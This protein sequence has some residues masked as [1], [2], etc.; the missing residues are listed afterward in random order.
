MTHPP[1]PGSW[2]APTP[3]VAAVPTPPPSAFPL[4]PTDHVRFLRTPRHR[5]W[6]SL[7]LLV[8]ATTGFLAVTTVAVL[9][10]YAIDLATGR[11][12]MAELEDQFR[13]GDLTLTPATFLANNVG[14]ALLIPLSGLLVWA[15][16]GQRPRWL[17]SVVGGIRWR[18][19][20]IV[21]AALTPIW[22]VAT[23]LGLVGSWRE[24]RVGPDTALLVVGILLT[25]PFQA[26][27]EE[28]LFRGLG[29]RAVG[30]FFAREKLALAAG[31]VLPSL[32]FMLAHGA[33]DPWLNLFYLVFGLSASWMT[34]RTG[35]LEAAI[36]LH[37]VNNLASAV[38]LPFT[39]ISNVMD[40]QAGVVQAVDIVPTLV[41]LVLGVVVVEVLTRRLRPARLGPP[42]G[43][44]AVTGSPYTQA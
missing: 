42:S 5:W 38:S 44:R 4:Q 18:W 21:A 19:L 29:A 24:F 16:T 15:F 20:L 17:S 25:Q 30:S 13:R 2:P 31:A 39:D 33:G 7:L 35:G 11:V 8:T 34:W 32:A 3:W 26:S 1:P 27:G 23:G 9:V 6:K 28:Y 22:I 10:A 36:A 14:L 12:T 43:P 37:V 40:R 41:T